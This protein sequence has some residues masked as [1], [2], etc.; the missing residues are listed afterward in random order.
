M[1][2]IL[3][4]TVNAFNK[5]LYAEAAEGL[6]V[7]PTVE[8]SV[9]WANQFVHRIATSMDRDRGNRDGR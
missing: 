7:L 4:Q 6:D 9:T 2:R 3:G 1:N 8:Q 5:R